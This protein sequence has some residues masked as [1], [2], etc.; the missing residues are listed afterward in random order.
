[1]LLNGKVVHLA[2]FMLGYALILLGRSD[3]TS[4]V[5][6][7]TKIFPLAPRNG[8]FPLV[9]EPDLRAIFHHRDHHLDLVGTAGTGCLPGASWSYPCLPGVTAPGPGASASTD[10]KLSHLL[11]HLDACR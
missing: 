4:N 1:M 3:V 5:I 11:Q 8:A 10:R 9:I 2:P 6:S 7:S